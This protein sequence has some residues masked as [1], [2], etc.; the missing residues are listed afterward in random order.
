MLRIMVVFGPAKVFLPISAILFA[1]G[2]SD[3]ALTIYFQQNIQEFGVIT[4][5]LSMIIS[6]FALLGE[7]IAR[8]RI[9]IGEV[10]ANEIR[11]RKDNH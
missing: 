4:I 3:I 5:I 6:V 8:I 2:I 1:M 9:E 7:Q 11:D 10:V